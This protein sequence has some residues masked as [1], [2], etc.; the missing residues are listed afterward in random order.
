MKKTLAVLV[1][2]AVSLAAFAQVK[3]QNVLFK[4]LSLGVGIGDDI[5]AEV[6]TTL[7]PWLQ[8]RVMYSTVMPYISLASPLA[9]KF[10]KGASLAPLHVPV[11]VNYKS[12]EINIDQVDIDGSFNWHDINLLFDL[13]PARNSVFHFTVGALFGLS[14]KLMT[15]VGKPTPALPQSDWANTR[16]MGVTTNPQG[17]I[18]I[19]A[20][21]S[22]STVKPYV[23]V[24]F[25]RPVTK[26]NVVGVNLDLG[27]A[28]IG[29]IHAY[30]KDYY[31][32]VNAPKDVEINSAWVNSEPKVREQVG[33]YTKYIDMLNS[34]PVLPILR[35]TLNVRLF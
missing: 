8:M 34:F 14:P 13:Y 31:G 32:D 11:N 26:N 22:M 15:A 12:A 10:M 9:D 30:S 16:F 21:F 6:A 23:G 24:G 4:H 17:N 18:D 3:N 19:E 5:H 33:E 7:T 25:G 2:L 20:R 29:G 28:Y 1:A 27:V 35:I